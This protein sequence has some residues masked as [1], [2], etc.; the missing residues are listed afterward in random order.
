M[1]FTN[2][3]R[4][5]DGG[6]VVIVGTGVG[7]AFGG[8][9]A[10]TQ[11]RAGKSLT[12][13]WRSREG[14]VR[15]APRA[16]D[17]FPAGGGLR[18]ESQYSWCSSRIHTLFWPKKSMIHEQRDDRL[19]RPAL[20]LFK[21]TTSGKVGEEGVERVEDGGAV[22]PAP[23]SEAPTILPSPSQRHPSRLTI[24]PRS[25]AGVTSLAGRRVPLSTEDVRPSPLF[26]RIEGHSRLLPAPS[27][28]CRRARSSSPRSPFPVDTCSPGSGHSEQWAL[29]FKFKLPR[30]F[31][32]SDA[33]A[34]E[35]RRVRVTL[36]PHHSSS[37]H[38]AAAASQAARSS[39]AR[40]A[41]RE[42]NSLCPC[43]RYAGI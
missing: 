32:G 43:H 26:H 38:S 34:G 6:G 11:S 30:G 33:G 8:S 28:A 21:F 37:S 15:L 17:K 40:H 9:Q 20:R 27:S 42:L 18:S 16:Y 1:S 35:P 4:K 3:E 12:T 22:C 29:K 23:G 14:P 2:S 31:K 39:R 36:V 5:A 25:Q 10:P 41:C 7:R 24:A 19:S 13:L